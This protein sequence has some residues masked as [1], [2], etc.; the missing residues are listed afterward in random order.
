MKVSV[1]R[2]GQI[3]IPIELRR[4]Y[5]IEVGM[6]L[7]CEDLGLGTIR[8]VPMSKTKEKQKNPEN[9]RLGYNNELRRS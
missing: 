9:A 6:K 3:T 1:N 7:L 2:K 8:I 4:K 5:G